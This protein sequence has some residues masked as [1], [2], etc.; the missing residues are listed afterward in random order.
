MAGWLNGW[1][2]LWYCRA[3][4]SVRKTE[5]DPVKM[6]RINFVFVVIRWC[7]R[8]PSNSIQD[9]FILREQLFSNKNNE[10]TWTTA[11]VTVITM[12]DI[13]RHKKFRK[14]GNNKRTKKWLR[15]FGVMKY[16]FCSEMERKIQSVSNFAWLFVVYLIFQYID[17]LRWIYLST[18]SMEIF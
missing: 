1:L 4:Y 8:L 12:N 5:W 3:I 10:R 6:S 16:V 11:T 14:S 15:L 17:R 13:T 2:A 18:L 9:S 7:H